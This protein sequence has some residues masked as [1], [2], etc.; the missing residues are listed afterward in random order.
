VP[1]HKQVENC[2]NGGMTS[3]YCSCNHCNLSVCSVCGAYEGAL[4]IDC[5]GDRVD[6]DKQQ[7]VY[8]TKLDFTDAKGWHQSDDGMRERGVHFVLIA[9]EIAAAES[10]VVEAKRDQKWTTAP[11]VGVFAPELA[12]TVLPCGTYTEWY[13]QCDLHN[14][15]HLLALR[16][17]PHA[18]YEV[19]IY[20]EAMLTLLRPVYP[21]IIA[22][23]EATKS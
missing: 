4:T 5:P 18:Q 21:T 13:W 20:A 8:T 14:T 16:L 3:R 7:E 11:A 2:L 22:A 19:R 12:R 9:S 17:D 23:W 6:F 15:L 10:A 1:L